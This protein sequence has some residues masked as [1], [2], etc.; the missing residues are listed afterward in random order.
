MNTIN[1]ILL[2][3]LIVGIIFCVILSTYFY[4]LYKN[5]K[6]NFRHYI[7]FVEDKYIEKNNVILH[8]AVVEALYNSINHHEVF[9]EKAYKELLDQI[10]TRKGEA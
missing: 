2:I 1:A 4:C 9:E 10:T 3:I 5:L 8:N 6:I 7:E